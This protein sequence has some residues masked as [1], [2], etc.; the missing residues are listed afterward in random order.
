MKIAAIGDIHSREIWKEVV[1]HASKHADKIVLLGD[2]IDPYPEEIKEGLIYLKTFEEYDWSKHNWYD[3]PDEREFEPME[4]LDPEWSDEDINL[5]DEEYFKKYYGKKDGGEDLKK[6]Y[7]KDGKFN[8]NDYFDD[9]YPE[10]KLKKYKYK[11]FEENISV[12]N[13]IIDFKKKNNDSVILLLGN[14]DAH[15]MYPEIDKCSRFDTTHWKKFE[16]RYRDNKDLFQYAYQ[17][18]NNLFTHAGVTYE[19]VKTFK[20]T[21]KN[22]GLKDDYSNMADVINKMGNN[23]ATNRILNVSGGARS[24][25]LLSGGPTWAD[26]DETRLDYIIGLNQYVG[27]SQMRYIFTEKV[28]KRYGSIT[29]CDVL[30]SAKPNMASNYKLITI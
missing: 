3:V 16:K 27:H 4:D 15:Y 30:G 7:D 18:K 10:E 17:I 6:Y 21:L 20:N 19:W 24:G 8:W 22:Q 23:P 12:L 11:T 1:E 25:S 26:Y 2:Y 28:P 14:H 9:K 29:Y 13:D 5:S